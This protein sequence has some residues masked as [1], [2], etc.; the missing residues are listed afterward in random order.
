MQQILQVLCST[1]V[2]H[3]HMWLVL[4]YFTFFATKD[5]KNEYKQDTKI[6]ASETYI[7]SLWNDITSQGWFIWSALLKYGI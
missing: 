4:V 2:L 5:M 3:L 1:S 6:A 7:C